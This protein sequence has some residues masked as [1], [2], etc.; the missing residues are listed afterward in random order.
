MERPST[1]GNMELGGSSH[2]GSR[3]RSM[4]WS[5][6]HESR[7]LTKV[8]DMDFIQG[9][10]TVLLLNLPQKAPS[11]GWMTFMLRK[12]RQASL[13]MPRNSR[14]EKPKKRPS[15]RPSSMAVVFLSFLGLLVFCWSGLTGKRTERD[16]REKDGIRRWA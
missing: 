1:V 12:P 2:S 8:L 10:S 16:A 6:V 15:S 4:E 3:A 14:T 9:W 5:S 13:L 7:Q 11:G